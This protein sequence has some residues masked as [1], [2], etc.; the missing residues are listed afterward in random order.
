MLAERLRGSGLLPH[1]CKEPGRRMAL[2]L[3]DN[4]LY[5]IKLTNDVELFELKL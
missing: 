4:E 1:L 2:M 5:V 3:K